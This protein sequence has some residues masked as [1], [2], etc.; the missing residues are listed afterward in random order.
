MKLTFHE[1]K[2]LRIIEE[3]PDIITDPKIRKE[4]A[5]KYGLSEKT[6]RNRIGDLKKYGFIGVNNTKK[7]INLNDDEEIADMF[8]LLN[9]I[10]LKKYFIIRNMI[11]IFLISC[12]LVLILPKTYTSSAVLMPPTSESGGAIGSIMGAL[13]S[14]PIGGFGGQTSDESLSIIAILKSRTLSEKAIKNFDLLNFY[15]VPN[16]DKALIALSESIVFEVL[17]EGTINISVSLKTKWFHND[18]SE[19]EV[20]TL[21]T[22]MALFFVTELD[23]LNKSL[24]TEQASFHRKFIEQRYKQNLIDLENAEDSL[25]SF[26]EKHKMVALNEQTSAAIEAAASIKAQML[27]NE[28]KLGVMLGALNKKHPDIE[29]IRIE[30][31]ELSKKMDELEYGVEVIGFDKSNLFPILSEIPELGVELIRLKREVEIQ[32]TLFVF[33]TQQYEEAKIKEAKDTPTVQILDYPKI[34]NLKSGPKRM[35][36]VLIC[37]FVSFFV[38]ILFILKRYNVRL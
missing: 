35:I 4:V 1:E 28:V 24:K 29:N 37:L 36:I 32:N 19:R 12:I 20:K 25:R 27:S 15:G 33:L 9:I 5:G 11:L 10:F 13:S 17:E 18:E 7:S 8:Q 26:Q 6:L 34:P 22:N 30:N 23:I 3:Y 14:L 31:Y 2:I 16:V 21:C 38:N